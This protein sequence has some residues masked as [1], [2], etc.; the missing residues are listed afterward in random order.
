MDVLFVNPDS[1]AKAYQGPAAVYTA[2]EPPTW[3]LLAK[4]CRAR[5][6]GVG[7]LDC[8]AENLTL[9]QSVS[10]VE[11]VRPRLVVFAVYGQNPNSGT[12]SMIGALALARAL[13]QA[14]PKHQVCFVGSHA[15]AL[16]LEVL[17]YDC[18]DVLPAGTSNPDRSEIRCQ[19]V[20][21]LSHRH[22]AARCARPV[23]ER[24]CQLACTRRRGGRPDAA[25]RGV[26]GLVQG[27]QHPPQTKT[28]G[29][30]KAE[31]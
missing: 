12:T 25:P 14:S 20:D 1:S 21:L 5:D 3:L 9:E 29:R 4:S 19:H 13:K 30:L 2:I 22:G 7:I 6:F 31:Q 18:V 15:S 23:Q 10:R 24:L 17:C 26:Q 8:D 27:S 11:D 16:P 28:A